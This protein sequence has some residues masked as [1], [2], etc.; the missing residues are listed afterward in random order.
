MHPG[1]V[2]TIVQEA[3]TML[4][5]GTGHNLL[6]DLYTKLHFICLNFQLHVLKAQADF[7]A[8][9]RWIISVKGT[10]ETLSIGFW[11]QVNEGFSVDVSSDRTITLQKDVLND[12]LRYLIQN[13]GENVDNG[14]ALDVKC[15]LQ[16]EIGDLGKT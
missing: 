5:K 7:L 9:T 13:Y 16:N 1:H 15:P 11:N 10:S 6:F 3:Q 4:T 12:N 14:L 8:R 2:N